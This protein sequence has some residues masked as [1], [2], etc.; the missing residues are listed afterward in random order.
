[1]RI[2]LCASRFVSISFVTSARLGAAE[3]SKR[4]RNS[5]PGVLQLALHASWYLRKEFLPELQG[6]GV[7]RKRIH[8]WTIFHSVGLC[9]DTQL[10]AEEVAHWMH[11][12][13]WENEKS[14]TKRFRWWPK[15]Y[16][17]YWSDSA[18]ESTLNRL[19]PTSTTIRQSV[20]TWMHRNSWASL[21]WT[22]ITFKTKKSEK[23]RGTEVRMSC[24]KVHTWR[25][26]WNGKHKA[27]QRC[28]D[29]QWCG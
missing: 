21:V 2:R 9:N 13:M 7:D 25:A 5:L 16:C 23:I 20:E 3:N 10:L 19:S 6:C 8:L 12:H 27:S 26:A 15:K 29:R 4:L 1:M 22:L 18:S 17:G 24:S 11:V 28:C 14:K